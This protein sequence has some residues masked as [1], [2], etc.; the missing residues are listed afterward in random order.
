MTTQTKK[1]II[2]S[3]TVNEVS[4]VDTPAVKGATAVLLKSGGVEIRKNAADVAAGRAEPLYKASDY[5]DA[6]IVRA[7]EIAA[8]TGTTPQKALLDHSG[9]DPV[10]IELAHGERAAEMAVMKAASDRRFGHSDQWS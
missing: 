3:M 10:L 5:G 7:G 2:R 4:S 8:Q 6:M 1:Q 9:T